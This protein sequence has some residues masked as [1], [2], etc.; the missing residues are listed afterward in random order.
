MAVEISSGGTFQMLQGF[1]ILS[2]VVSP[3][4]VVG[5]YCWRGH[6]RRFDVLV[7]AE[8]GLVVAG[9]RIL[10]WV[11]EGKPT[12][13][14]AILPTMTSQWGLPQR[15]MFLGDRPSLVA[16]VPWIGLNILAL[17]AGVLVLGLVTG[18]LGARLRAGPRSAREVLRWPGSPAGVLILF[19]GATA[20]GLLAFGMASPLFDRYLWPVV[21][22]L[23]ILL[24]Y[25]PPTLAN[26]RRA[27]PALGVGWSRSSCS[28]L[29]DGGGSQFVLSRLRRK[30][31]RVR[32]RAVAGRAGVG[33]RRRAT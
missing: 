8:I 13:H 21:P 32:R 26:A 9:I 27:C 12:E 7:G 18:M 19:C 16:D 11:R 17:A 10:Q 31:Q 30:R 3:A 23:A 14:V 4:A 5:A 24:M 22:P 25:I 20:A 28:R 33:R 15:E 6:L 2:L 1:A 29:P